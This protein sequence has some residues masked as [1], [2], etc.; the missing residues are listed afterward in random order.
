MHRVIVVL[1][2][3]EREA[4]LIRDSLAS[5]STGNTCSEFDIEGIIGGLFGTDL[6]FS[7]L[8]FVRLNPVEDT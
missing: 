4:S 7:V 6:G 2:F 1:E 5:H 3:I 8:L